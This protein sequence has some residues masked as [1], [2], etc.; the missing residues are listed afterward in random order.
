MVNDFYRNYQVRRVNEATIHWTHANRVVRIQQRAYLESKCR[1]YLHE[2]SRPP[3][4]S[5][6][7]ELR[8]E[9]IPE[10]WKVALQNPNYSEV[11]KKPH[12]YSEKENSDT[13]ST[14]ARSFARFLS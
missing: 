11:F 9:T 3:D 14:Y 4:R 1:V 6:S 12:T 10:S 13:S 8:V 5:S 7:R 2:V